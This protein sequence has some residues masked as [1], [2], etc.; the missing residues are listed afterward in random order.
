[1]AFR[2]CCPYRA[3]VIDVALRPADLRPAHLA[4][5]IDVLRATS[6][7]TQALASGY[8]RVLVAGTI[9]RALELRKSGRVL[10]GERGGIKP[11]GFDQG[12]SP[13][14]VT[15]RHGDE[16]VLTTTNGAPAIMAATGVAPQVRLACLLNLDASIR[17][18]RTHAGGDVL[19]VCSGTDGA[20]A[21]EDVY[22]AGRL[23]AALLGERS[24]AARV[25]QAVA[26]AFPTP[27]D[28]LA[29]SSDAAKLRALD[30]DSD[31]TD[32]A[33]ESTLD[34]RPIVTDV[35]GGVATVSIAGGDKL[36]PAVDRGDTV[37][38]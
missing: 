7:A 9:E 15:E 12:N 6:T 28:A 14:E 38:V 19:I 25:A 5:V 2:C 4:V 34:V 16:L 24:D 30:L 18:L 27:L 17:A 23:S 26:A 10:A 22:V 35:A 32:C 11:P 20:V 29:A 31:I 3:R 13:A 33:V 1:M 21:L 8:R 36:D 37:R